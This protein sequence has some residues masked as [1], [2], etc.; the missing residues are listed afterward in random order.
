[1]AASFDPFEVLGVSQDATLQQ[2]RAAY[3]DQVP[4]Y[5]PDKHRGNP[6]EELARAKLVEINRAWEILSD[7]R[8]RAEFGGR[9]TNRSRVSSATDG[10]SA[11]KKKA[12][13][14][15]AGAKLVRTVGLLVT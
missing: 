12:A 8:K 4:R 5:H 3:R 1:M 13:P 15:N 14:V 7:D 10:Y 9:W 2:I 11:T 6:L